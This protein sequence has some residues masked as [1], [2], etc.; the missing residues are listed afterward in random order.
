[1]TNHSQ[2][3][4]FELRSLV[5]SSSNCRC[6]RWRWQKERSCKICACSPARV[7]KARDD[8]LTVAEDPLCGRRI[9]PFG[10]RREHHGDLV[11]G[12]FQPVQRGVASSTERGAAGRASKRLDLLGMP[13]LAISDEGVELSIGDP[14]VRTLRVGTSEALGVHSLGCSP[15]AFDLAPGTHRQ[16]RWSSTRRGSGDET[17]GGAIVWAAGLE[18]TVERG[19]HLGCCSRLGRT[20]MGPTQ[21]TKQHEREQEEEHLLVHL[22]SSWLEMRS[23]D[24]FLLIRKNKEPR[25][26]S[27]AGRREVRIIHHREGLY[28]ARISRVERKVKRPGEKSELSTPERGCTPWGPWRTRRMRRAAAPSRQ[29]SSS[30]GG[31]L[32]ERNACP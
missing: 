10:Q 30:R 16:R 14:E 18:Q 23:R 28:Q 3:T 32:G 9:Q 15:P 5:C 25:A 24:R 2:S 7:R 13:M 6:G 19:A 29:P 8:R 4:C 26:G 27:Q 20:W 22:E 1:M 21:G 17:T 12:S 11:R 31:W